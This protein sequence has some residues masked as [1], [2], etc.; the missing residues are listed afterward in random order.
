[1]TPNT[2]IQRNDTTLLPE[3]YLAFEL[4]QMQWKLGFTIGLG[5]VGFL[6]GTEV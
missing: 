2:T 5:Q 6:L 4:S 3:L 1:M